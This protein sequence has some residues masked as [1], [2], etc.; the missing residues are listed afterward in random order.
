LVVTVLHNFGDSLFKF[1]DDLHFCVQITVLVRCLNW[2]Y[3]EYLSMQGNM[4]TW[5]LYRPLSQNDFQNDHSKIK[6]VHKENAFF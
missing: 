5:C 3:N 4:D 1:K 2:T 6:S